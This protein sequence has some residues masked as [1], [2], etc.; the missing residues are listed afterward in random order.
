MNETLI[1]SLMRCDDDDDDGDDHVVDDGHHFYLLD[2]SLN[3]TTIHIKTV[4]T[5]V[6]CAPNNKKKNIHDRY[7]HTKFT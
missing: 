2:F 7:K 6:L 1:V 5:R 4:Y 3:D